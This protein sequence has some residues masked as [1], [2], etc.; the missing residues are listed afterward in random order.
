MYGIF[1][2]ANMLLVH[3]LRP[4]K[5]IMEPCTQYAGERDAPQTD[6]GKL[7]FALALAPQTSGNNWW[8]KGLFPQN[9]AHRR[10]GVG[11]IPKLSHYIDQL[12]S[13]FFCEITYNDKSFDPYPGNILTR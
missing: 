7:V 13:T 9:I 8:F 5:E 6:R 1:I 11:Q 3:M 4:K 2:C 10:W 12:N